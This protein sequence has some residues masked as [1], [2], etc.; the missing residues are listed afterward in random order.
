MGI[1]LFLGA[2]ILCVALMLAILGELKDTILA[3]IIIIP[4][5]IFIF[6]TGIC[7]ILFILLAILIWKKYHD[8]MQK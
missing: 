8:R 5:L 1:I 2:I 4:S 7:G 3:I 6:Y